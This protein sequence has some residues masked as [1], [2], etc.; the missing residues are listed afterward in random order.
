[1]SRLAHDVGSSFMVRRAWLWL[2]LVALALGCAQ[3]RTP[4]EDDNGNTNWL[5]CTTNADCEG[6]GPC[7][8]GLCASPSASAGEGGGGVG[9][10]PSAATGSDAGAVTLPPGFASPTVVE[11]QRLCGGVA[12]ASGQQCCYRN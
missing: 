1:M 3:T 2:P 9:S 6:S 5:R 4:A 8:S 10:T 12:C 7:V 11:G